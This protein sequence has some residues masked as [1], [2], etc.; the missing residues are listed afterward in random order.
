MKILY[1]IDTDIDNGGAPISTMI[2]AKAM[3]DLGHEVSVL[4]PGTERKPNIKGVSFFQLSKFQNYFPFLFTNPLKS[5]K[6]VKEIKKM[7]SLIK[8]DIIH[9][10]MPRGARAIGLLKKH[11]RISVPIVYTDREFVLG[12]KTIYKKLYKL[13]VAKPFD[14]IICLSKIATE[15]WDK[16]YNGKTSVIPNSA[17]QLFDE[18]DFTIRR[19]VLD[20]FSWPTNRTNI[21]FVGRMVEEKRWNII[22]EIVMHFPNSRRDSVHFVFAIS[23][24]ND[25]M[26]RQAEQLQT[27]LSS[28]GA[29]SFFFNANQELMDKLYYS[30]DIHIITSRIE[31]FGRTAIEAMSRKTVVLCTNAGALPE[32]VGFQNLILNPSPS[33]FIDRII[34]FLND[35]DEQKRV[36][37][38]LF[39][40][41]KDTYTVDSVAKKHMEIYKE[42]LS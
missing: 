6:L 3:S 14:R 7:I 16:C 40:K 39:K 25:E 23:Y 1:I 17:G 36:K 28:A 31:S 12:L 42:L 8:P 11:H 24:C 41:Y 10:Q 30:A 38:E 9:A 34:Y 35:N 15:Y 26:K 5:L 2:V 33:D 32:T 22:K 29:I 37:E 19:K 27:D 4:M 13:L 20:E 18:Y 21:L